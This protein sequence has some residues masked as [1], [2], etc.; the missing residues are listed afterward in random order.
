MT[1]VLESRARILAALAAGNVRTGTAGQ[2]SAPCVLVEPGDPWA[3]WA[4]MPGRVYRWRLTAV[5]GR[6]DSEGSTTALAELVDKVDAALLAPGTSRS[7][8][9]PTWAMPLDQTLGGVAYAATVGTI[10]DTG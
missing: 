2:F 4:R 6:A 8:Q 5:G 9:L 3:E 1:S 10:Q 7:T